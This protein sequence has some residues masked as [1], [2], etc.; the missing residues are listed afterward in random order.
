VA[1]DGALFEAVRIPLER[2]GRYTVCVS[3][4]VGCAQGCAFCAT[5]RLS[6][7]RNLEPW[8]MVEQVR[9]IQRDLVA[10]GTGRV[11][12]VVFQGMGEPLSN[13]DRVLHAIRVLTESGA[14]AVDA[15]KLTVCTA[16]IP[17]GILRLAAEAP[18]VR[19]AVSIGSPRPEV[20]RQ[21]MPLDRV[22]PLASVLEVTSE[23]ARRTGL[24][25]M[26]AYTLLAG[27]ND[28]DQDARA[29]AALA[30][31]FAERAGLRPRLTL[32]A[33]NAIEPG[34]VEPFAGVS[35]EREAV[36]RDALRALGVPTHRR[37]S[38]GADVGAACGQLA[39]RAW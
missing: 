9:I 2:P 13:L 26:W 31:D 22:H 33:Y 34:G 6:L 11:H 8:E 27:V 38:G 30:L 5:G 28:G 29:L 32:L 21:I 10:R 4:Q 24:A 12:G 37:Y 17:A 19:L 35:E 15:K 3:S 20:R 25:P 16:G 36:F 14:H 18:K 39:G 23:H 1:P 7:V